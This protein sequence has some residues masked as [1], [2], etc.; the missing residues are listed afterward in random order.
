M[1]H[2]PT[3]WV[4]LAALLAMFLLPYLSE[5]LFEGPRT[6]RHWPRRHLCGDC[7]VP[8]TDE[9]TC[10]PAER[11]AV[12]PLRGQLRRLDPPARLERRPRRG[13]RGRGTAD[14]QRQLPLMPLGSS[15]RKDTT[16]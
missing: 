10:P 5:R 16:G 14:P 8:W 13:S 9:H 11:E 15:P 7:N 1:P 12:P 6:I 3:P 2:T 4:G